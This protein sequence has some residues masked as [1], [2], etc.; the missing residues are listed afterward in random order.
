MSDLNRCCAQPTQRNVKPKMNGINVVHY[1]SVRLDFVQSRYS[2]GWV[3]PACRRA[4][5]YATAG[6]PLLLIA[7]GPFKALAIFN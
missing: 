5:L 6:R 7:G 3:I 4:S 1:C 2:S